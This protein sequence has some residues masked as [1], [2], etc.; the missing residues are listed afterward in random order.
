MRLY[1]TI[2]E[3]QHQHRRHTANKKVAKILLKLCKLFL[4]LTHSKKYIGNLFYCDNTAINLDTHLLIYIP[5][6]SNHLTLL[7]HIYTYLYM[8]IRKQS[9][10]MFS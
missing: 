9:L 5:N 2:F 6:V 4:N 3:V 8:L 1:F 7:Y 10:F